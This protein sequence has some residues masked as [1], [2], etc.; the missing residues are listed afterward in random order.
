MTARA[1]FDANERREELFALAYYTCK[2]CGHPLHWQGTA[3]LAHRIAQTK[4]NIQRYG[5]HVVHHDKNLVP[6][7]SLRCNDACNIGFNPV[8]AQELADEINNLK[9]AS[10]GRRH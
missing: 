9:E 10:D 6:V 3:Q 2:V 4:S 1:R 8:A 7:C 5:A